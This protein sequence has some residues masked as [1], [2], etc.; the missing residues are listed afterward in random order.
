MKAYNGQ[1]SVSRLKCCE[2]SDAVLFGMKRTFNET[3]IACT[4]LNKQ[5]V[6]NLI[7]PTT[8]KENIRVP[9]LNTPATGNIYS[10]VVMDI[11]GEGRQ[12]TQFP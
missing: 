11:L 5:L 3:N 7:H 12:G 2:Q 10:D 1:G 6:W 9:H 8:K 4:V